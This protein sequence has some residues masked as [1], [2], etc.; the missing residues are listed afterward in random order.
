MV[1]FQLGPQYISHQNV[2]IESI[3][4]TYTHKDRIAEASSHI[5]VVKCVKFK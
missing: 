1:R 4:A 3:D 2:F 5:Y